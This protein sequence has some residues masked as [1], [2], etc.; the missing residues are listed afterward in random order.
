[1][2]I[3]HDWQLLKEQHAAKEDAY[4]QQM[5][6][7]SYS[8]TLNGMELTSWM[9]KHFEHLMDTSTRIDVG[10]KEFNRGRRNHVRLPK[11]WNQAPVEAP[12]HTPATAAPL[13]QP[14]QPAQPAPK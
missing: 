6:N 5:A 3:E 13:A 7:Q 1:V 12:K 8:E 2:N 4:L 14:A 9:I 11:G 10:L